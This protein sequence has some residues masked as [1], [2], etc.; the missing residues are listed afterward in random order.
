L[1]EIKPGEA[2]HTVYLIL[3]SNIDP[4]ENTR[5]ALALLSERVHV[6][7]ISTCWETP[8]VGTDGPQFINTA[9]CICTALEPE[10]LKTEVLRAIERELGRVRTADKYAPRPIDLDIVVFDDQV[11]DPALWSLAYLA[12]PFAELL[13]EFVQPETGKRLADIAAELNQ[14]GTARPLPAGSGRKF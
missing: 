5:Q 6:Q 14:R 4:L 1:S 11:L 8:P 10:A 7:S 13:P 3:G 2:M 9:V 12:L